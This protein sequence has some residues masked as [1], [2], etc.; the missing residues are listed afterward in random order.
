MSMWSRFILYF[1][2]IFSLI[3]R[4][5]NRPRRFRRFRGCGAFRIFRLYLRLRLNITGAVGQLCEKHS[6]LM[7][8]RTHCVVLVLFI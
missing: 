6:E 7:V 8:F 3:S 4:I 1:V 2:F 5:V